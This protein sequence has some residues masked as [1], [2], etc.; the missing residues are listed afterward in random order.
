MYYAIIH[1]PEGDLSKIEEIDKKYN[2]LHGLVSPHV[3]LLFPVASSEASEDSLR[4]QA[5]KVA[6]DSKPFKVSFDSAHTE[7]SFDQWLFLTPIAGK[8]ELNKL[9]DELYGGELERFLRRDLPFVPHIGI[10]HFVDQ[11]AR[12]DIK[13]PQAV[14]LDAQRY[15]EALSNVRR[16]NISLDYLAREIE[17]IGVDDNFKKSWTIEKFKLGKIGESYERDIS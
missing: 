5:E 6:R 3:T 17:L 8:N 11:D 13:N 12:Y 2:P 10:G 16:V 1:R 9:H 7:L 4:Q 14:K 15:Q